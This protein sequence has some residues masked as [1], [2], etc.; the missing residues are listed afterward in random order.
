MFCKITNLKNISLLVFLIFINFILFCNQKSLGEELDD[1]CN[2][3]DPS[4][5]ISQKIPYEIQI[6]T[7]NAKK[8][9]KN[10]FSLSLESNSEKYKTHNKD[11]FNFQIPKKYKKKFKS[12]IK[13]IFK[14]PDY[15]C[16]ADANINVRGNL[17]WHLTWEK[18]HPFASLRVDLKNGHLNNITSFNLLIPKSRTYLTGDINLEIFTTSLLNELNFL[19]PKSSLVKV[20]INGQKNI[21]LMQERLIKEFLETRNL[22]EGPIFKGDQRFTTEVVTT[23][24]FSGNLALAKIINAS[25]ST[26]DKHKKN[27][28]FYGL[29]VLNNIFINNAD[30]NANIK[31]LERCWYN[32]LTINKDEYF[33]DDY[34]LEVN[35]IYESLIYA[36]QNSHSLACDDRRFYLDPIK[37]VFLPIYN[38][39]K[40]TLRIDDNEI[41]NNIKIKNVTQN[42]ID[43]SKK[44]LKMIKKIDDKNFYKNILDKGF[45]LNFEEYKKIKYKVMKNLEALSKINLEKN[46]V[47]KKEYFSSINSTFL[48]KEVKLVFLDHENN[49]EICD[50]KI[51]KCNKFKV[52]NNENELYKALLSQ[53]FI[54]LK[55][56]NTY[57]F[58]KNNF[59]IFL[60]TTKKY[61]D[62]NKVND[63]NLKFSKKKVNESF[64]FLFNKNVDFKIDYEKK[65]IKFNLLEPTAR[66]KVLGKKV[67]SWSFDIDGANYIKN[68]NKES[69]NHTNIITGCLSFID[70]EVI[71]ISIHSNYSLCEDAYNFIR[72]NGSINTV[73]INNSLSDGLDL[74]FSNIDISNLEV[75]NSNNDCVDMSY[76]NYKI[77]NSLIDRCGDKGISVG[78]KSKALI[79]SSNI[80]NSY[81]GVASKDSAQVIIKDS[82]ISNT[83]YCLAAYRK[84]QE[85]SGSIV[86]SQNLLCEKFNKLIEIDNHS[87]IINNNKRYEA[88]NNR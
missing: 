70:L 24:D 48:K 86:N 12:K 58:N 61:G 7:N 65:E 59:Y 60:S 30:S 80:S 41:S 83:K 3:I 18:G 69:V 50:F 57:S 52:R 23:K 76:G 68:K 79:S 36:T 74:D 28:S 38:D 15:E 39:G 87:V 66:I 25:Y 8:W 33:K 67:D 64:Y 54:K 73:K 2:H 55:K 35:Q 4:L 10:I 21:Y 82:N 44:A 26:K 43:G 17:W 40:S 51:K 84:K 22:I 16:V 85:F 5:L 32:A 63:L 27:L 56:D 9:A 37:K 88:K 75:S 11:H 1:F 47:I 45:N 34:S 14:N 13:F 71:N 6:E 53:N 19:A 62:I 49:L 31:N 81:Y 77:L 72:T 42:S 29:S 78:E 46:F 20:K